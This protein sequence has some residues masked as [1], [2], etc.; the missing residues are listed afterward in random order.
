MTSF[1]IAAF[2]TTALLF[3]AYAMIASWSEYA[4]AVHNTLSA[5]HVPAMPTRIAIR[6]QPQANVITRHRPTQILSSTT[7]RSTTPCDVIYFNFADDG[8]V[9]DAQAVSYCA[10]A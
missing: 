7:L 10:A 9:K 5:Y 4:P 1:L 3:S 2:F 6:H 8:A